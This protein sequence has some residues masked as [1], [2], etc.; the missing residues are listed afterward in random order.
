VSD[1]RLGRECSYSIT[2]SA[3]AANSS[4]ANARSLSEL[5]SL[6]RDQQFG[7]FDPAQLLER[8]LESIEAEL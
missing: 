1:R 8:V 2:S 4:A 6:E 5:P 3:R 7:T